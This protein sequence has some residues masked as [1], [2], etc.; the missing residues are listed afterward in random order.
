MKLRREFNMK[1]NNIINKHTK[2]KAKRK[3]IMIKIMAII[4]IFL[5]ISSLVG[6]IIFYL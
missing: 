3:K 5:M 6:S 2:S 1:N 4:G